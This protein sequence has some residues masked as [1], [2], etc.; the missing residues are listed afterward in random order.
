MVSIKFL[1]VSY[2]ITNR[3]SLSSLAFSLPRLAREP[4]SQIVLVDGFSVDGSWEYVTEFAMSMPERFIASQFPPIGL[5]ASRNFGTRL[6]TQPW[7]VHSGPDSWLPS[8]SLAPVLE[9]L[10]AEKIYTCHVRQQFADS[11]LEGGLDAWRERLQTGNTK[12]AGTPTIGFR[13]MFYEIPFPE[14]AKFSDD[15]QWSKS[16]TSAGRQIERLPIVAFEGGRASMSKV[17]ERWF[18]YGKSDAEFGLATWSQSLQ[19]KARSVIHSFL[20]ELVLPIKALRL[21]KFLPFAPFFLITF[22]A[23]TSGFWIYVLSSV[24]RPESTREMP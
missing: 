8:D 6:A 7:I 18:G 20:V 2:I 15:T 22:L 16:L 3:N 12:V 23:R 19:R 10:S 24:T 4:W 13:S 1:P 17:L 21:R 14:H 9:S 5:G 11:W